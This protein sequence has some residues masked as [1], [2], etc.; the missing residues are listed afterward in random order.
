MWKVPLRIQLVVVCLLILGSAVT[1]GRDA[2]SQTQPAAERTAEVAAETAPP[3]T[4]AQVVE[5]RRLLMGTDFRISVAG[6]PEAEAR[7]SITAAFQA[8][9]DAEDRLHPA[10]EG[11]DIYRINAS[12]G[13]APVPVARQTLELLQLARGIS[14][15]SAGAF[16]IT[17]AALS[18]VWRGLREQPPRLPEPA[19]IERARRLVDYQQLVLDSNAGTVFL[20]QQGMGINVGGIGKGQAV[21]DAADVLTQR[22]LRNFIVG[23]GGDLLVRG[24]KN[25]GPWR[26][27]VQ[28][29]RQPG[30]LLGELSLQ[31]SLSVVTS[32]DYERFVEIDGQRYHHIIDVRTGRPANATVAVTLVAPSAAVADAM[33]TA[34]FV[35]GPA[36]GM[37]LVRVTEGVEALIID[38]NLTISMSPGMAQLVRLYEPTKQ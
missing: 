34:V 32:G 37:A 21:D 26:L 35:M 13:V 36:A 22:G 28:H 10:R 19:A 4:N 14:E 6:V 9:A 25:G 30:R 23:G 27:G 31:G 33:A 18:P 1:C 7:E 15:R 8:V 29:P 17:Y 3:D 24:S 38:P 20:R 11:S 5:A 2:P 16:D 12:A